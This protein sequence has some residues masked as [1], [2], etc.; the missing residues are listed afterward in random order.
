[1]TAKG[2][3][4]VAGATGIVGRRIAERLHATGWEV[5]GLCRRPPS[6]QLPYK[7]VAVDLADGAE[8][9][10]KLAALTTVTHVFYAARYDHPEG[11][12][13][14]VDIN[15]AMLTNLI[16]G[17]EPAARGLRHVNLVHGT[18][19][20]G[21]MLGP[22]ELPLTEDSP[23]AR[24][25]VFYFPQE[26]FIRSRSRGKA[27]TYS[28]A[29]PHTFC[30]EDSAEPRNAALLIAL[31]ATLAREL[32]IPFVFPGS[33]KAFHARTQFTLVRLLARAVEWMAGE[34][35][36]ENQSYNITNGDS[37]RWSELWPRFADYFGVEAGPPR[38]MRLGD[39]VSANEDT[40]Q[41]IAARC[42]LVPGTLAERVL[43]PYADYLFAPE[44]DIISSVSKA[45][46][47]GF[48]ESID[49]AQM[50]IGLFD[51]FRREKIIP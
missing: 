2:H 6:T 44:W 25:P 30:D 37:P 42:G 1:M 10:P 47:D 33:E 7:L 5:T 48:A 38:K 17:I 41:A 35:R 36:C 43:W 19:Y 24:T 14:S 11:V 26:D 28:T 13:E 27:W 18:K 23:R 45:R 40:W 29:R 20:Y 34:P 51:G 9:R 12:A 16:D 46:R 3:A 39:C 32:R 4:L 21:H 50:F 8:C 49:S 22:L 15:A 31:H